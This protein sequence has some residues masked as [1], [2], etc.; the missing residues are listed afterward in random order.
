MFDDQTKAFFSFAKDFATQLI[1]LATGILAITI[2]LTKDVL[3]GVP[4]KSGHFLRWS[5]VILL[6]SILFGVW[7]LSAMTGSLKP[8][9]PPKPVPTENIVLPAML[10]VLAFMLGMVL[11]IRYGWSITAGK[12]GKTKAA[13]SPEV[14]DDHGVT[15]LGV[16]ELKVEGKQAR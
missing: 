11:L 16:Q 2:S 1:T 4:A 13:P 14:G 10:Q 12:G 8:T 6:L 15:S 7:S 3:N 9:S 5:W